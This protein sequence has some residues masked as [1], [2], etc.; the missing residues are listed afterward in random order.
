M[1]LWY[2][3]PAKAWTEALPIGN[4]RL[5]A[6]VFGGGAD[7]HLQFNEDTLWTGTP[8]EY[9]T[10]RCGQPP[11]RHP[12]VWMEVC[13]VQVIMLLF[14]LQEIDLK[15]IFLL[16]LLVIVKMFTFQ[17]ITVDG[18][19]YYNG[20][21]IIGG[22]PWTCPGNEQNNEA[23]IH[24][25]NCRILDIGNAATQYTNSIMIRNCIMI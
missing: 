24:I 5:G 21:I 3:K 4:G 9:P 6:M 13:G 22:D 1:K 18:N 19:D 7:E 17:N 16:L 15:V 20:G 8:H 25:H 2:D 12:I 14:L 10:P 23:N 11:R